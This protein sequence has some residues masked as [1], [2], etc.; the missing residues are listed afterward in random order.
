MIPFW[1][2]NIVRHLFLGYPKRDHNFD[3]HPIKT[4]T[5]FQEPV[6]LKVSGSSVKSVQQPFGNQP[7]L[8]ETGLLLKAFYVSYHDLGFL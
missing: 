8:G 7:F 1:V 6:E 3:N 2:L 4:P 5:M